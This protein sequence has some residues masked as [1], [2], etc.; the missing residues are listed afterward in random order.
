MKKTFIFMSLAVSYIAVAAPAMA[1]SLTP[2]QV[3]LKAACESEVPAYKK[4]EFI[5]M[6]AYYS[7]C[8]LNSSLRLP[9]YASLSPFIKTCIQNG[10]HPTW[11]FDKDSYSCF[12]KD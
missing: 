7:W 3:K 11:Y 8:D 12:K 2:L 4:P 5:A 6:G 1:Q 10:G 9:K